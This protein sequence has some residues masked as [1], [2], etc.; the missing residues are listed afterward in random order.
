M[1]DYLISSL[2]LS[3]SI[4]VYPF[5]SMTCINPAQTIQHAHAFPIHQCDQSQKPKNCLWCRLCITDTLETSN[6]VNEPKAKETPQEPT[7]N[8]HYDW[9]ALDLKALGSGECSAKAKETGQTSWIGGAQG[10]TGATNMM[11]FRLVFPTLWLWLPESSI[12]QLQVSVYYICVPSCELTYPL[13]RHF[14]IWFSFSPGGICSSSSLQGIV[15]HIQNIKFPCPNLSF[16][17][18]RRLRVRSVPQVAKSERE[19]SNSIPHF[20]QAANL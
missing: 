19:L 4:I 14:W 17:C 18:R 13:P 3:S 7:R 2:Y 5:L 9:H 11:E 16:C 6:E 15:Y 8:L 10:A 1:F 20:F 12:I